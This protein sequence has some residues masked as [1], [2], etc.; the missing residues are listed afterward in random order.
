MRTADCPPARR[1]A[2]EVPGEVDEVDGE[3]GVVAIV[4]I[5]EMRMRW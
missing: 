2:S 5:D 4:A 3:G 1:G